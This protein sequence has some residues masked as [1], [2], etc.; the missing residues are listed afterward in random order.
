MALSGIG[1]VGLYIQQQ[2]SGRA[3]QTSGEASASAV[4]AG[5][6]GGAL[7]QDLQ[8]FM[9]ALYEALSHGD[10]TTA[11][12]PNAGEADGSNFTAPAG[13]TYSKGQTPSL[14]ASAYL[15]GQ[16]VLHGRV[17]ALMSALTDATPAGSS[18]VKLVGLQAAFSRL[19][20]DLGG[21]NQDASVVSGEG[22][23]LTLNSWLQGLRQGMQRP[24]TTPFSSVGNLIDVV[25]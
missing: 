23:K 7:G 25:V 24:G 20:Q 1:N 19:L 21:S 12:T 18:D 11:K 22:S 14:Q 2:L 9:Q 15:Q 4:G 5:S 6:T 13:P 17:G 16:T 8:L 3:A 10:S